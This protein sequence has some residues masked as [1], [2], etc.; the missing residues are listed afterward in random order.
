MGLVWAFPARERMRGRTRIKTHPPRAI[1]LTHESNR[2][3]GRPARATD[4]GRGE[5]ARA[6][7]GSSQPL[8]WD[9]II[10]IETRA[11]VRGGMAPDLARSTVNR[12]VWALQDSGVAAPVRVPQGPA[13]CSESVRA[14]RRGAS[15]RGELRIVRPEP[16]WRA[17]ASFDFDY[18]SGQHIALTREQLTPH[19]LLCPE[20]DRVVVSTSAE[21]SASRAPAV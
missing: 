2:A 20:S 7:A 3:D 16:L 12:A 4:R 6:F 11:P 8:T 14:S 9:V 10:N 17:G 5:R 21:T 15:R 18:Y 19:G 13:S 1:P